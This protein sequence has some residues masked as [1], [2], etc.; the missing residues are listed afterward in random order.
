MDR[1]RTALRGR[2]LWHRRKL[3][4]PRPSEPAASPNPPSLLSIPNKLP[5]RAM[6][7]V[8][9]LRDIIFGRTPPRVRAHQ[10][11]IRRMPRPVTTDEE[12]QREAK[13]REELDVDRHHHSYTNLSASSL[14]MD[15]LREAILATR[16][17]SARARAS[18]FVKCQS[19]FL[20]Q[21]M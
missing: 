18:S 4:P 20:Y 9:Q 6:V 3:P 14:V 5:H 13:K 19:G 10:I 11:R 7:E 21:Y 16:I 15:F 2:H 17:C 8:L 1:P 12:G